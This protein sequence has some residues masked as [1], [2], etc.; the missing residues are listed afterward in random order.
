M[1]LRINELR[2]RIPGKNPSY[3]RMLGK[4]VAKQLSESPIPVVGSSRIPKLSIRVRSQNS[5]SADSLAATIAQKIRSNI[6]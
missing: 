4:T 6:K 1:K 3:G 2:L 5:N